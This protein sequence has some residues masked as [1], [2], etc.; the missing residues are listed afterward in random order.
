MILDKEVEIDELDR[1]LRQSPAENYSDSEEEIPE[2]VARKRRELEIAQR[3]LEA[4]RYDYEFS[5]CDR[6]DPSSL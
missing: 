4:L 3:Q 6:L 2:W 5:H 1:Q